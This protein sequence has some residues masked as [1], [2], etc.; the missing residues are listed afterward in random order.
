MVMMMMMMMM[1]IEVILNICSIKLESALFNTVVKQIVW[2]QFHHHHPL[3]PQKKKK[4][5]KKKKKKKMNG[6]YKLKERVRQ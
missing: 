3:P 1:N 6:Q 5:E 4:K 2:K